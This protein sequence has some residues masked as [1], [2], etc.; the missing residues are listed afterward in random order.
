MGGVLRATTTIVAHGISSSALFC[1][2][3]FTY[4]K[5]HSRSLS[6][7]SGLLVAY[8]RLA[9]MWFI[10]TAINI[11]APGTL[12]LLGELLIVPCLYRCHSILVVV[13]GLIVFF[14]AVYNM[15]LYTRICHGQISLR[16]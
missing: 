8:P 5:V 13:I 4:E 2:A 16:V 1:L 6:Y 10:F 3:Y 14:R 9:L 12:N 11:A 7:S 15:Y